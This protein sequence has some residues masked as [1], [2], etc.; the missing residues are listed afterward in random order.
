MLTQLL[1]LSYILKGGFYTSL[2]TS[3]QQ[4]TR[5]RKTAAFFYGKTYISFTGFSTMT[6]NSTNLIFFWS[7]LKKVHITYIYVIDGMLNYMVSVPKDLNIL[8]S[9]LFFNSF[10][11]FLKLN[12][13]VL[14]T[15]ALFLTLRF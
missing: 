14:Q 3:I 1:E 2:L 15:L 12:I 11:F 6:A 7:N 4:K 9:I 5:W 8:P 10:F 13:H